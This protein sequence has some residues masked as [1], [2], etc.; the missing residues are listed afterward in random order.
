MDL[1]DFDRDVFEDIRDEFEEI[2]AA[3]SA[4]TPIP[5]SALHGDNVITRSDRTR[6]GS[7]GPSLLEYLETV[8]RRHATSTTSPFRFPVQLVLR[9]D[10]EFRGY[11]GQ[12]AVRHRPR[13]A[14][15]VTA[16]PS[17]RT[18]RVKRIVTWDGDLDVAFAPMS[19]TLT[20]DDEIDISRGDHCSS[21]GTRR[22]SASR[23][24]A[25]V[26]WMD[27]RPLD[28]ARVYLLKHTTRTV[29]RRGQSAARA[30]P[31][32]HRHRVDHAA[33]RVRS[34][35]RQPD[36]RQLHPDRPR[37]RISRQAPA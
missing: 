30:E 10:H 22:R 13:R 15:Q 12:I 19:V 36:D 6:R 28:P 11:A 9:P 17:G 1:V 25:D 31:D 21:V 2:L 27:E 18:A 20:L 14:T 35:R 26:V 4:A 16:W 33:A 3:T 7:T 37:D 24:E 5:L 34:L 32:R 23:F 29:D 8:E